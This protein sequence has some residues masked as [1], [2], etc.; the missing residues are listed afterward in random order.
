M[1][2]CHL[3]ANHTADFFARASVEADVNWLR[4]RVALNH[5]RGH[6]LLGGFNAVLETTTAKMVDAETR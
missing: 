1:V 5:T 2:I 3:D 6:D 4:L